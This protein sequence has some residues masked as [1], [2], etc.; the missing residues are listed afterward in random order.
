MAWWHYCNLRHGLKGISHHMASSGQ[1]SDKKDKYQ[2]K[3]ELSYQ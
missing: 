2:K 3:N 1:L